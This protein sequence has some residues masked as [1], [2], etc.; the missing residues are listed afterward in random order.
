MTFLFSLTVLQGATLKKRNEKANGTGKELKSESAAFIYLS[1]GGNVST[2]ASENFSRD[3]PT[4]NDIS[5]KRYNDFDEFQ[6]KAK[7][8]EL[9]TAFYDDQGNL[10]GTCQLKTFSDLPADG[11]REINSRYKD[12]TV[13][14]VIFYDDN[15][16]NETDMTLYGIQFDDV[17]SYFVEL[18][19]GDKK[20]AVQVL[21]DGQVMYFTDIK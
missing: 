7:N 14:N 9:I 21:K 10:V 15:E 11:Q 2:I 4:A 20:I 8:G 6:F 12:Y 1:G 19:K 18:T 13:G 3:F 16:A 5:A 17:D